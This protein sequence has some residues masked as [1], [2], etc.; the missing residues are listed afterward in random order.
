MQQEKKSISTLVTHEELWD[1][2]QIQNVDE[3]I[4]HI[5]SF[6]IFVFVMCVLKKKVGR[7]TQ[8]VNLYYLYFSDCVASIVTSLIN[9]TVTKFLQTVG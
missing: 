3:L 2:L 9:E 6:T 7:F 5:Y 1:S 4:I 8:T